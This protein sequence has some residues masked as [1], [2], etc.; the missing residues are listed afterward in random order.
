MQDVVEQEART[1]YTSP[2]INSSNESPGRNNSNGFI[3]QGAPW[4]QQ[5]QQHRTAPNTASVTEFPSF[6]GRS[7]EPQPPQ[8]MVGAWGSKR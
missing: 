8:P 4:E 2:T 7:E 6:G 1:F 5:Q 3:V